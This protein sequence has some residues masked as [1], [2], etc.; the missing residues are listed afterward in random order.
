MPLR[1]L[2]SA[3]GLVHQT[4]GDPNAPPV[5]YLPGVH[6]DWTPQVAARPLLSRNYHFVETAY[7]RIETWSIDDYAHALNDLLDE[8]GIESAHIVGESFGSLVG[9]EFGIANPARV[10][11]FTLVGGF[12]RPPRF[13][14]AAAA[15][16]AL[17]TLPTRLLESSI[18]AYVAGKSAFGESR[19]TFDVGAYPASRTAR[20]RLATAKRMNIIQA[21]DFSD[22]LTEVA[23]PV[24]YIG[25][26]NDIVVPVRREIA[27]LANYLPKHCDFQSELVRG[28]PHAMIASHP[29]ATVDHISRWVNEVEEIRTPKIET[30]EMNS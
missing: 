28:A 30:S 25:G 12:S 17:K 18:D 19:E 16:A 2:A 13:R 21:S 23:F 6:G 15:A 7:P 1:Q 8:L 14:I 3:I 22:R 10:R 4:A 5:L 29:E 24:R 9:W 11:S 27:T 20:G 26:A